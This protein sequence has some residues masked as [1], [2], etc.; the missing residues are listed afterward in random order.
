MNR[1]R[2][3]PFVIEAIDQ[4]GAEKTSYV[5]LCCTST[6]TWDDLGIMGQLEGQ[7]CHGSTSGAARGPSETSCTLKQ[8]SGKPAPKPHKAPC[9]QNAELSDALSITL[10]RVPIAGLSISS[11]S[12]F[13]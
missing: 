3:Q 9:W 7:L 6:W 8:S 1:A 12:A 10:I 11:N 5:T 2:T 13:L 4:F